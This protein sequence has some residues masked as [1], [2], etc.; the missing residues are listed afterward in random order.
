MPTILVTGAEG[1]LGCEIKRIAG[2][3]PNFNFA[4]T[5]IKDLDIC[6]IKAI[7]DYFIQ[8]PANYII[9]CAA[10]TNVDK[11]E[12]DYEN[13]YKVNV[14]AVSNLSDIAQKY[15]S[16]LIHISTDYV[17]DSSI[18]NVP[19]NETDIPFAKSVYGSTK[20]KGEEEAQKADQYLIIRTSWLYSSYGNNFVKTILRLG[21]E[22]SEL[23]V[24]FDQVGTPC[25][26]ADLAAIILTI[27]DFSEKS[28]SFHSGIYHYSNEGVCSWYDFAMEIIKKADLK[29]LVKPIETKDYPLPAKRPSY[30]VLNKA[31]IKETFGIQ[32]PHWTDGLERCFREMHGSG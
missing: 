26:A 11:A 31:K 22:R 14:S 28:G 10:F 12:S 3:Y 15:H 19:F 20:L 17:F 18:K 25:Y 9:N 5:D 32:I 16:R 6:N 7:E 8:K 13:A 29:C 23:G 30:S 2:N 24:I 21:K 1:Q 27:I 4:Y